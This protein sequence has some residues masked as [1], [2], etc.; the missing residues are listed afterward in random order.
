VQYA[1][2]KLDNRLQ[3]KAFE[4]SCPAFTDVLTRVL[5]LYYAF[6]PS[7]IYSF[8]QRPITRRF[9]LVFAKVFST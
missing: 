5:P 6:E 2:K 8:K 4:S 1:N 3:S 9:S 7:I